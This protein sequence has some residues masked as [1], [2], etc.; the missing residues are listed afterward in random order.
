MACEEGS[1]VALPGRGKLWGGDYMNCFSSVCFDLLFLLLRSVLVLVN[2][3]EFFEHSIRY[4]HV[5]IYTQTHV[6]W[7]R[8]P[9]TYRLHVTDACFST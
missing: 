9:Y 7:V 8:I 4:T 1:A 2:T 6:L 5:N 3:E